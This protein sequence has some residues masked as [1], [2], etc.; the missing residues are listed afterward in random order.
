MHSN[1]GS[2]PHPTLSGNSLGAINATQTTC[3]VCVKATDSV[4]G[5][6]PYNSDCCRI[7]SIRQGLVSS[8]HRCCNNANVSNSECAVAGS[9]TYLTPP[10]HSGS[11]TISPCL[12][13]FIK[14]PFAYHARESF[15]QF[16]VYVMNCL[17]GRTPSPRMSWYSEGMKLPSPL[18]SAL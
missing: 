16:T 15:C 9:G 4:Q 11:C 18:D 14:W 6:L 12:R 10:S 13:I 8:V 17:L 3:I 7:Q 1:T 5:T 2:V